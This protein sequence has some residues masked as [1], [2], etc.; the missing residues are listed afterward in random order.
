MWSS[1]AHQL[2]IIKAV[3]S[4]RVKFVRVIAHP[5]DIR[6]LDPIAKNSRSLYK[7]QKFQ[8]D[9]KMHEHP[10]YILAI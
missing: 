3:V 10:Q 6:S 8:W 9:L 2:I 1:S 7:V 4:I 5:Y